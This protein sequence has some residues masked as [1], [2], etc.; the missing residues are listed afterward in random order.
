MSQK[1]VSVTDKNIFEAD[2]QNV[3]AV[4]NY[5]AYMVTHL[6]RSSSNQVNTYIQLKVTKK[7]Q[8]TV[9]SICARL[10]SYWWTWFSVVLTKVGGSLRDSASNNENEKA[11]VW[12]VVWNTTIKQSVLYLNCTSASNIPY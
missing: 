6:N 8:N 12:N 11:Q 5:I 7:R 10:E 1:S 4:K 2:W 9:K 3:F